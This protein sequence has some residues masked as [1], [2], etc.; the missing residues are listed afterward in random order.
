MCYACAFNKERNAIQAGIL[1]KLI[2]KNP[3]A[4]SSNDDVPN[5]VVVIEATFRSGTKCHSQAFHDDICQRCGD[6]QIRTSR[7]SLYDPSLK[8]YPGVPLMINSNRDLKKK[9]R[10]NGTLCRGLK[11]VLKEGRTT[12]IKNWDGYKVHT[13]SIDD[14]D[15]M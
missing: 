7:N 6:T 9:R 14:C 8:F 2:E 13:V 3:Q 1:K 5:S 15:H 4:E 11:L 10:G 12:R